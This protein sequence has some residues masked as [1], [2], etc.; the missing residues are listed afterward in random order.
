LSV[1]HPHYKWIALSNTTLGTLLATV[2]ASIVLISLPAIFKGIDVN[3]L[4]PS[5]VSYLLWMLMGYMLVTAVLVVTLGRLGDMYGRVKIYNAGFAIFTIT[6]IILSLDPF[7]GGGGA[8]WLIGWRVVQAIGGAMLMANSA[9]I[10]TDAFPA[11]QRGMA[12]GVNIVSALAGSFIGLVAGGVLAEWDWRSIFWVNIPL[13]VLGTVWAY[14]SLHDT[15][16]R[17]PAVTPE[18]A[19]SA[20]SASS[21][22]A[23]P[24]IDWWGNLT[25]AIGLTAVL[26]A[27]TYGIQPYGG[28]TEGWTNPWVLTGL[29]GGLALLGLFVLIESR[30]KNP[31]FSLAL[32]KIRAFTT[33]NIATLLSSIA[34]GGMQFMLI[35]WLQGIW[36]PLHGYDFE[37]TPLWAGIYL[38]PLTVGFLAAGPLAGRL[39]D[40]HGARILSTAGLLLVAVTFLGL[41]LLPI[42]FTYW[43]FAVLIALN[44]AGSGLFAAP[45]TASVMSSVPASERGAAAGMGSTFMTAGTVLSIG[46]FFSLLI[47]GLAR[48][49][50]STLGSGLQAAGVPADAAQRAAELP[51]VGSVFAAFLG[52]NPVQALLG[53]SVL[54]QLPPDQAA[55]ITGQEFFPQLISDPV[56]SGLVVVF[57]AAAGMAVVAAVASALRGSRYV[58]E[59]EEPVVVDDGAV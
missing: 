16:E 4:E 35:I 13:G 30:V 37:Q 49:L 12:L 10:I 51:P 38:L 36:L 56:H 55:R 52:F 47:A 1:D 29:F 54:A 46:V 8:L 53:P 18:A 3:P 48:S 42:D 7:D 34:R 59:D 44:G 28:H 24:K 23:P 21:A 31:M 43:Q 25:F 45:N 57:L 40:R 58:H 2:N 26:A 15:G 50:P 20:G 14:R 27:I 22:G 5:N 11:E 32:F 19:A 17:R 9:A 39:S 33:G 6:S 41:L